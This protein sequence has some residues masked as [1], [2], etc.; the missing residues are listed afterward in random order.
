MPTCAL[1]LDFAGGIGSG[2]IRQQ[3]L[4]P[5][6]DAARTVQ[7][8]LVGAAKAYHDRA[9]DREKM[10]TFEHLTGPGTVD[11]SSL[12]AIGV[13]DP[14]GDRRAQVE[15]WNRAMGAMRRQAGSPLSDKELNE[16]FP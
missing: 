12:V 4:M 1:I 15:E 9:N 10:V 2:G 13:D 8:F 3:Y 7:S 14:L 16:T 5:D 6:I 11:V